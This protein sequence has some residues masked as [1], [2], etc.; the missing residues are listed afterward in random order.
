MREIILCKYGEIILKGANKAYFEKIL[1]DRLR[2]RVSKFGNFE[3]YALQ[4]TVYIEPQSD[5]CDID[6]AY[7]AAKNTFG[8]A[9]V[10]RAIEADKSMEALTE[11]AKTVFLPYLDGVKTSR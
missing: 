5:D 4:S 10:S 11:I 8:V 1:R 7:I 6:S 9:S 3:V 2:K